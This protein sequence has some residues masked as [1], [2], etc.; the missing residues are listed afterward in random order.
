M[1]FDVRH[2]TVPVAF[3]GTISAGITTEAN[4]VAALRRGDEAAFERLIERYQNIL[5]RVAKGYV[6]SMVV[7]EEV[8]QE[9]WLGLLESLDRFEGR[10]SLKTWI[11]RILLNR[12]K[13]RGVREARC[14]PF[15]ALRTADTEDDTIIDPSAFD[16]VRHQW[17]SIPNSWDA[18]PET[19]FLAQETQAHIREAIERL[20]ASQQA[21]IALRDIAGWSSAEVCVALGI[22]EVN[23]RVLLHRA[24]AKVR[25]ALDSYFDQASV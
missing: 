12:A 15:S 20:P 17:T 11:F 5:L 24:R 13:S 10:C 16:A 21:V 9:T 25:Q 6:G 23:Q 4:L 7:A 1:S 14:L 18:I 2:A 22:S 8:V 3:E 19:Q